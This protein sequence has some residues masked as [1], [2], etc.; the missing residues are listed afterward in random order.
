MKRLLLLI[1]MAFIAAGSLF[2]QDYKQSFGL[3]AGSLNGLSYKKFVKENVAIQT[4]LA[5]GLL[6]TRATI[7]YYGY[8]YSGP[9]HAWTFQLQPNL[10][11]QKNIFNGDSCVADS[12]R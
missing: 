11:Y 2:A 4:D 5:F 12:G 1:T 6:A 3:V 7:N 8:S 10:Y 9:E